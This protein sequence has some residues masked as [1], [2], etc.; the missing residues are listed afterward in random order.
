[1][2]VVREERFLGH[3]L[4]TFIFTIFLEKLFTCISVTQTIIF[5]QHPQEQCRANSFFRE[6]FFQKQILRHSRKMFDFK[7]FEIY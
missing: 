7:N 1:M 4:V 3:I 2:N 5:W 6:L